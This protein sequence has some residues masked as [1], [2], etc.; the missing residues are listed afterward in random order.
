MLLRFVS[1]NNAVNK[2][3]DIE[4]DIRVENKELENAHKN[5]ELL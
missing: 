4:K 5:T 1:L 3:E 2:E